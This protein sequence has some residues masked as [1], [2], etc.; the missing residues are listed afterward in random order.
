VI[1]TIS[2]TGP[3]AGDLSFLFHKHPERVQEF[4]LSLGRALVF[5]PRCDANAC[6]IALILDLDPLRLAGRGQRAGLPLYPYVN[7]R[8]YVASSF[9]SVA[10][11]EVFKS[12]LNGQCKTRPKLVNY[13]FPFEVKLPCLRVQG[14]ISL[15]NLFGPLGYRVH[16]TESPLDTAFPEWGQSPYVACSLAATVTLKELLNHLYVLIPVLDDEKHYWIDEQE[17]EKLLRRGETWL[18]QHPKRDL[19]VAR[20]LKRRRSL[21]AAAESR[22]VAEERESEEPNAVE[23]SSAPLHAQRLE[24]VAAVLRARGVARILDFGCGDCKLLALLAPDARFTELVGVDASP[25]QLA[26]GETRLKEVN[27]RQP[28]RVRLL[29]GS[30]VYRDQRLQGFDAVTLVEVIEH[31]DPPRLATMERVVFQFAAPKLILVTT[32]NAEYNVQFA[33]L[34]AEKL[35]HRDHRFEWCRLDFQQ[36]AERVARRFGYRFEVTDLGPADPVHGAPSQMAVFER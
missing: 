29:Q 22:L 31:L 23:A 4:G 21:V 12:A 6:E 19:I 17:V 15:S 36:W 25:R 18:A 20:Y 35:R 28:G 5:Y 14:N 7:D 26:L 27:R 30:L 24:A 11:A 1:L 8:P 13:A 2:S 3:N 32:P 33:A 16:I 9:L 10:V 34:P